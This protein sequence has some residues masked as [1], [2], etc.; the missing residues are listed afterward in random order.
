MDTYTKEDLEVRPWN[1][2][3][4]IIWNGIALPDARRIIRS[5]LQIPVLRPQNPSVTWDDYED[6]GLVR[7][8]ARVTELDWPE[9]LRM[10]QYS[11][12]ETAGTRKPFTGV[13]QINLFLVCVYIAFLARKKKRNWL[14]LKLIAS[15][16]KDMDLSFSRSAVRQKLQDY[17]STFFKCHVYGF[18]PLDSSISFYRILVFD[19]GAT[20]APSNRHIILI[21]YNHT[22]YFLLSGPE[23]NRTFVE[24]AIVAVFGAADIKQQP[25]SSNSLDALGKIIINRASL[26]V[27]GQFR[28]LQRDPLHNP[29]N[30]GRLSSP[31]TPVIPDT[32]SSGNDNDTANNDDSSDDEHDHQPA[33]PPPEG[34]GAA[35]YH[36]PKFTFVTTREQ[37]RRIIPI[38]QDK[39]NQRYDDVERVFGNYPLDGLDSLTLKLEMS[40]EPVLSDHGIQISTDDTT[41][42]AEEPKEAKDDDPIGDFFLG[43]PTSPK[44]KKASMDNFFNDDTMVDGLDESDKEASDNEEDDKEDSDNDESPFVWRDE[45]DDPDTLTMKI[46]LEGQNVMAGLRDLALHGYIDPP[47]PSWMTELVASGAS[48]AYIKKDSLYLDVESSSKNG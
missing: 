26:G 48:L 31:A 47:Y 24:Q 38:Q 40:V 5:W 41:D 15:E 13:W 22:E 20:Q 3:Q 37:K 43:A 23:Q 18:K 29:L 28:Y 10:V 19:K 4:T 30:F 42:K 34:D 6:L 33:M 39:M 1:Q 35:T 27:F 12:L 46:S 25:L 2:A 44:K 8:K 36:Y 14:T 16:E 32:N 17:L 11:E 45:N 21:H 9:G 7:I